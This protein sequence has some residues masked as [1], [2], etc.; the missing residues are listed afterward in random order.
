MK[1]EKLVLG[2]RE[3][4]SLDD[5]NIKKIKVKVDTGAR[6]SALHANNLKIIKRG[7]K[8]FVEFDLKPLQ[9][10]GRT[11]HCRAPLVGQKTVKSSTGTST[12]RPVIETAIH[13]GEYRWKI[14]VTLVNRDIMGFRMLL[15]RQAMR[16]NF[17]VDP[18]KSFV[19]GHGDMKREKSTIQL[20]R[21]KR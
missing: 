15:G 4:A 2:W 19:L 6:T 16:G 17:L 21:K 8:Q 1:R 14:E 10:G 13:I 5:L 12:V 7:A 9:D 18:G 20:E 3:W 11:V